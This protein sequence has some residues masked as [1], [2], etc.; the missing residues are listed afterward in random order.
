M[1][2]ALYHIGNKIILKAPSAFFLLMEFFPG[3][4]RVLCY[5]LNNGQLKN[6]SKNFNNAATKI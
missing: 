2:S 5:T 3:N 1:H 6:F 4:R